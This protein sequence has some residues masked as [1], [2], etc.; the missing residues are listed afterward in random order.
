MLHINVWRRE[1]LFFFRPAPA[2][3]PGSGGRGGDME[4]AAGLSSVST[5]ELL[6]IITD[7]GGIQVT[8][9]EAQRFRGKFKFKR[10]YSWLLV[11]I[12]AVAL[13]G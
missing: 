8:E 4:G 6:R 11:L 5:E 2:L 1:L 10:G 3:Q 9:A 13:M 12:S 7:T